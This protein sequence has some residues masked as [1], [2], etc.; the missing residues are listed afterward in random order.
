M[1][2]RH[3][4]ISSSSSQYGSEERNKKRRQLN[5]LKDII[6][7]KQ[8]VE[9]DMAKGLLH[10]F[11][12]PSGHIRN[13]LRGLVAYAIDKIKDIWEAKGSSAI[14]LAYYKDAVTNYK[15]VK[16]PDG[17]KM[18]KSHEDFYNQLINPEFVN[19]LDTEAMGNLIRFYGEVIEAG[20]YLGTKPSSADYG[21]LKKPAW[22]Q[23]KNST[24]LIPRQKFGGEKFKSGSFKSQVQ[25]MKSYQKFG[26]NDPLHA[27]EGY[28]NKQKDGFRRREQV[29]KMKLEKINE[30]RVKNTSVENALIAKKGG[31]S[32][33][34][35]CPEDLLNKIDLV[36]GLSHGATISGTT[37]DNIFF[38]NSMSHVDAYLK[39]IGKKEQNLSIAEQ[40]YS[41]GWDYQLYKENKG[42][43]T[44]IRDEDDNITFAEPYIPDMD[45][46]PY[47]RHGF[48]GVDPV[49]YMLPLG[50]IAGG[51]HHTITEVALPLALNLNYDGKGNLKPPQDQ[52][53][54]YVIGQYQGLFPKRGEARNLTD[55]DGFSEIKK[56]LAKAETDRNNR[57][58]LIYYS[59]QGEPQGYLEFEKNSQ[60]LQIWNE[61]ARADKRLMEK[62]KRFEAYPSKANIASLHPS[63]VS[64]LMG[65]RQ[66]QVRTGAQEGIVER[67]KGRY[68]KSTST[69]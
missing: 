34:I 58:I 66:E 4:E 5:T 21:Y 3:I 54:N 28:W 40:A 46:G 63:L 44:V 39:E 52:L 67:M 7:R 50:T 68:Q 48:F 27:D 42:K 23:D 69:V 13:G 32:L 64:L 10:E 43:W 18:F 30:A 22:D 1:T 15:F 19:S 17:Q 25:K 51:A 14:K 56:K 35:Q 55:G 33:F 29:R 6:D 36:F 49:Y 37:A 26:K 65:N 61:L 31:I 57:L 8:Q 12:D 11:N 59:S 53:F 16:S 60:D 62:I 41:E 2:I 20:E 9:W 45:R 38:I 47:S 24:V